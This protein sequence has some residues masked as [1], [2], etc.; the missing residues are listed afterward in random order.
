MKT[1]YQLV[2]LAILVMSCQK[3]QKL[4][5]NDLP[6]YDIILVAGQSNT[7]NGLGLDPDIDL[8]SDSIDQ[9]GRWDGHNFQIIPAIEPLDHHDKR[10]GKIG[11]ALTFAKLYKKKHLKQGRKLILIACG[12]GST[13]FK[14]NSWNQGD[15]L[16]T[17]A[18]ERVNHIC[19]KYPGSRM[20]AM[21]W[22]QGEHDVDNELYYLQLDQ[23]VMAFRNNVSNW[24]A[25]KIFIAGGLVPF[26]TS[27]LSSRQ[28]CNLIIKNIC[29]RVPFTGFADPEKPYVIMKDDNTADSIHFDA[30]GQREMGRRY[31]NVY[32]E[33]V[34]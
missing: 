28:K 27:A 12:K 15:P 8:V 4:E 31:F 17:D 34:K 16:Y 9:L 2:I 26:W 23:M 18:L 1:L 30:K 25:P 14:G 10:K 32:D 5:Q 7:L 13:G 6:Q 11:F 19:S 33:M 20:V 21:L 22:H 24:Q 3:P 29:Y